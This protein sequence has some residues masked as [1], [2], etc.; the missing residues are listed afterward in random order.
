MELG[1]YT[2]NSEAELSEVGIVRQPGAAR[3]PG[4]ADE[5]E[6]QR[7]RPVGREKNTPRPVR[8]AGELDGQ[9]GVSTAAALWVC[10]PASGH[11]GAQRPQA[12][13]SVEYSIYKRKRRTEFT[14]AF[15]VLLL[16]G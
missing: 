6:L 13:D 14:A 9:S 1:S 12:E 2:G 7:P 10:R 8:P 3:E 4:S 16:L 15:L 11:V 5:Q